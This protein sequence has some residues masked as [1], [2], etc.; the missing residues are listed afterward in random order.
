MN[1]GQGIKIRFRKIIVPALISGLIV[2]S[3]S[4]ASY[5]YN[6][7]IASSLGVR[8]YY[9]YIES[10]V[11]IRSMIEVAVFLFAGAVAYF[12]CYK[13]EGTVIERFASGI[14]I[15]LFLGL[16]SVFILALYPSLLYGTIFAEN[17]GHHSRLVGQS[18]VNWIIGMLEIFC[19]GALI[20]FIISVQAIIRKEELIR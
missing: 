3:Y 6:A 19:G 12:L 17:P 11:A 10:T 18:I 16:I 15:P 5:Y 13:R 20:H 7:H 2:I 14:S 9:N 1:I 4:I 8:F